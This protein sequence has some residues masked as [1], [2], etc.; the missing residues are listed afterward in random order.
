MLEKLWPA[1]EIAPCS[2]TCS[3][4]SRTFLAD[5]VCR[6][7]AT[8][9]VEANVQLVTGRNLER[10]WED[11]VKEKGNIQTADVSPPVQDLVGHNGVIT[12]R[13]WPRSVRDGPRVPAVQAGFSA[14]ALR[15]VFFLQNEIPGGDRSETSST[16][17]HL[18]R[19]P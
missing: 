1:G 4:A 2:E 7:I 8:P 17:Y 19:R 13:S 16:L 15:P 6:S 9:R 11:H 18:G 14:S 12:H 3:V 5:L 10:A